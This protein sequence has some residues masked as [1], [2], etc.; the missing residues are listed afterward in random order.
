MAEIL[1][2]H[3][4]NPQQRL[5]NR[6]AEGIQSGQLVVYPTDSSYAIGWKLGDKSAL[7]SIRRI[8]QT[9]RDH[10]FTLLCR[11]LAELATYA[12]VENWAYRMMKALTPGPYT[13]ILRASK[14]VP[15]RLQ[16]KRKT[17]GVRVPDNRIAQALLEAVGEPLMSS[18]LILPGDDY[19]LSDPDEIA[20][21]VGKLVG[22]FIDGGAGGLE[23]TTVLDLSGGRVEVLRRG[24]GDVSKYED[25]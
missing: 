12:R 10:E 16:D 14:D 20:D 1:R 8:R 19:P 21:R 13:F 5:I 17:I 4:D 3:P 24:L 22:Y 6:A 18:S 9:E 25:H 23:P 7:E 2:I 15:R 11:D